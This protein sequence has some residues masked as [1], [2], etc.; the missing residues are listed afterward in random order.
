VLEPQAFAWER[1]TLEALDGTP[2]LQALR[3]V[4]PEWYGDRM[5]VLAVL[6]WEETPEPPTLFRDER[7]LGVAWSGRPARPA[8]GF[9]LRADSH[10]ALPTGAPS[11]LTLLFNGDPTQP[12]RFLRRLRE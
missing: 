12:R 9:A 10:E 3:L 5:H 1:A 2:M 11:S 7:W 4:R 6:S 8:I